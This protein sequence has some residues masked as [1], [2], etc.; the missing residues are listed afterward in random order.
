MGWLNIGFIW[1]GLILASYW[2]NMGWPFGNPNASPANPTVNCGI[3]QPWLQFLWCDAPGQNR[4][5]EGLAFVHSW[6]G[7]TRRSGQP[8]TPNTNAAYTVF[9]VWIRKRSRESA[10]AESERGNRNSIPY[11]MSF[12][13]D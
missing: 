7:V 12:R 6:G 10:S 13:T 5:V 1:V 9:N 4:W 8:I 3:V 2:L 11:S